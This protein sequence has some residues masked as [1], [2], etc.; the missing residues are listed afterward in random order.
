MENS[1][2]SDYSSQELNPQFR[3]FVACNN[4]EKIALQLNTF[5]HFLIHKNTIIQY[6]KDKLNECGAQW[7]L[8]KFESLFNSTWR[9]S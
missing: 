4:L 8:D 5:S 3:L 7:K 2:K 1:A 6:C 9:N